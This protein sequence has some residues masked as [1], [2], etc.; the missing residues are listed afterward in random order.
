MNGNTASDAGGGIASGT[1]DP[2]SV[3]NLMVID[4]IVSGNQQ[5]SNDSNTALGGGG[6]ANL[7][8]TVL[9]LR[10]DV[11]GNSAQ[12]FVGGGIANGDYLGTGG[13]SALT[14]DYSCVNGNAAPNAGGGGIQNLLGTVTLNGS[15]VNGNTSLNGA[16]ISSGNA[17]SPGTAKLTL[18]YS[19]VNANTASAGGGGGGPP[20][21]AGGI[22]NGSKA[23]IDHSQVEHNKA[24]NGIGAGIVNHGLMTVK[25]SEVS[26]NTASASGF[27]GSGGGIL[28][29]EGPPG[30]TPAVLTLIRTRVIHNSAGS[31]GYG[32][33]IA[34]GVPLPGP[35]PLIGGKLVLWH[36]IVAANTAAHGGG[37][38][39]NL[40]TVKLFAASKVTGNT[41]D[42]CEPTLGTC[43]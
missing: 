24:P 42:N 16:G 4:S 1:F 21:A 28:N 30:T 20:V 22:A 12:G 29:S 15:Q 17:G 26:G 9:L 13:D 2:S 18:H 36:T 10:S 37:I 41:P 33:G 5:T 6:I 3:A 23:R 14:L 7:D 11:I 39:N 19:Q 35:M 8:G 31:G 34:N 43:T 25:S 32:G 27:N 38:F 40:G